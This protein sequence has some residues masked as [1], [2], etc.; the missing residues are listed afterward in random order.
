MSADIN[1]GKDGRPSTNVAAM[2]VQRLVVHKK[3]KVYPTQSL[4]TGYGAS[5]PLFIP[6][7]KQPPSPE[8]KDSKDNTRNP[9]GQTAR[10]ASLDTPLHP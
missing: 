6:L 2:A 8:D 4:R 7:A 10:T 1:G 5:L 3:S 9:P